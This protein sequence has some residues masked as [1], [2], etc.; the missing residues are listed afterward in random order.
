MN[1]KKIIV[2]ETLKFLGEGYSEVD[3]LTDLADEIMDY[4][5]Q[6]NV[7]M[8]DKIYK[9]GLDIDT[10]QFPNDQQYLS[11]IVTN[12]AEYTSDIATFIK[13]FPVLIKFVNN[14]TSSGLYGDKKGWFKDKKMIR[15]N[16]NR[17]SFTNSI[18][19]R[20]AAPEGSR[21]DNY[22]ILRE[23]L[24]TDI[25]STLVHELQHAY[26]DYRSGGKYT[27]DK[28]SREYYKTNKFDPL[29][30]NATMTDAQKEMYYNLPHE[31]WARFSETLSRMDITG[32]SFDDVK[33]EFA[34]IYIGYNRLSPQDQRRLL[35]AL[36]KYVDNKK[37]S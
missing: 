35:K 5:A 17:N 19:K 11:K 33:E 14:I 1:L 10:L 15:L 24:S 16:L 31:Q 20:T 9:K 22:S 26:D 12:P 2:E 34:Q 8:I 36:Y 7:G 30:P 32:K 18:A 21:I 29:D 6:N 3:D 25:K 13:T 23:A 28:S 4:F 37:F 27:T